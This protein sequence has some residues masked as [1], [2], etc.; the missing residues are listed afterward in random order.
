MH[1]WNSPP[2]QSYWCWPPSRHQ[3]PSTQG[4]GTATFSVTAA[5][6]G[7]AAAALTLSSATATL[8]TGSECTVAAPSDLQQPLS[9]LQWTRVF[10][11]PVMFP[12]SISSRRCL[13]T[14]AQAAQPSWQASWACAR[15]ASAAAACYSSSGRHLHGLLGGADACIPIFLL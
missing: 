8:A 14:S 11:T 1:L 12:S 2:T 7:T 4:C 10:T 6:S 15:S 3:K 5:G 13:Q 9:T